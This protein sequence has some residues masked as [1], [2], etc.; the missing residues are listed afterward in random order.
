MRDN[1]G[2]PY[3]ELERGS[4]D[5]RE[6]ASGVAGVLRIGIYSRVSCGPHWLSIVRT[7]KT[8]HPGYDVEIIDT[9]F[10]RNYLAAL[11]GNEVDVLATRLPLSD[12]DMT[13]GPILSSEPRVLLVAQDDPLAERDSVPVEDFAGRAI[14]DAPSFPRELMD[15]FFP[16]SSPSGRA[17]P[18]ITVR[19]FEELL[20]LVAA[21]KNVHPTVASFPNHCALHGIAHVP[22]SDL[23]PSETAIV[24]LSTNRSEISRAFAQAAADV[25]GPRDQ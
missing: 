24:W 9:S 19:S 23:P 3:A 6:V 15:A 20:M 18:R 22:I 1:L 7:F 11:R 13:V 5:A 10:G 2:P 4:A 8:R 16:P 14:G 17:F 25:L 21:G 12:D